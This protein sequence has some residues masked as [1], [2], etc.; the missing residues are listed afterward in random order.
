VSADISLSLPRAVSRQPWMSIQDLL[1]IARAN[2]DNLL[3]TLPSKTLITSTAMLTQQ[4]RLTNCFVDASGSGRA[5]PTTKVLV[6]DSYTPFPMAHANTRM[7]SRAQTL[8]P[9]SSVFFHLPSVLLRAINGTTSSMQGLFHWDVVWVLARANARLSVDVVS[10]QA[11]LSTYANVPVTSLLPLYGPPLTFPMQ[12]LRN[13]SES[14]IFSGSQ[15]LFLVHNPIRR[16]LLLPAN[17]SLSLDLSLSPPPPSSSSS[18]SS[19]PTVPRAQPQRVSVTS[20]VVTTADSLPIDVSRG[21]SGL[22]ITRVNAPTHFV[23]TALPCTDANV[24][25]TRVDSTLALSTS[26]S[27]LAGRAALTLT[28]A[29]QRVD[30]TVADAL[31]WTLTSS[32]VTVHSGQTVVT[33]AHAPRHL[34]VSGARFPPST[35]ATKSSDPEAPVPTPVSEF[36]VM[37][38][39]PGKRLTVHGGSTDNLFTL[40]ALLSLKGSVVLEGTA[41]TFDSLTARAEPLS[42]FYVALSPRSLFISNAPLS[43]LSSLVNRITLTSMDRASLTLAADQNTNGTV[44]IWANAALSRVSLTSIAP[45]GST[46]THRLMGCPSAAA[47]V[48]TTYG[49]QG[50]QIFLIGTGVITGFACRVFLN[51]HLPLSPSNQSIPSTRELHVNASSQSDPLVFSLTPRQL[52]VTNQ[53]TKETLQVYFQSVSAV[54]ITCGIAPCS[55]LLAST[56]PRSLSVLVRFGDAANFSQNVITTPPLATSV[57]LIGP[58]TLVLPIDAAVWPPQN[59]WTPI[60][61]FA[62]AQQQTAIR[63]DSSSLTAQMQWTASSVCLAAR[64]L[65]SP[66]TY[67]S[68]SPSVNAVL[69]QQLPADILVAL[70]SARLLAGLECVVQQGDNADKRT[71]FLLGDGDDVV[72]LRDVRGPVHVHAGNGRNTVLVSGPD[73]PITVQSGDGP[74]TI[75]IARPG[76]V[77]RRSART[78]SADTPEGSPLIPLFVDSGFGADT[79]LLDTRAWAGLVDL[80]SDRNSDR[81]FVFSNDD[82]LNFTSNSRGSFPSE[83]SATGTAL[84][85]GPGTLSLRNYLTEDVVSVREGFLGVSNSSDPDAMLAAALAPRVSSSPLSPSPNSP[86]RV[87]TVSQRTPQRTVMYELGTNVTTIIDACT[88]GNVILLS[89]PTNQAVDSWI[90]HVIGTQ[91][92]LWSSCNITIVAQRSTNAT[93]IFSIAPSEKFSSPVRTARIS[94]QVTAITAGLMSIRVA[95]ISSLVLA[96]EAIVVANSVADSLR[97][98]VLSASSVLPAPTRANYTTTATPT[99][100]ATSLPTQETSTSSRATTST[101]LDLFTRGN[102]PLS[103]STTAPPTT[104]T[105]T[106]IT[107]AT[108]SLTTTSAAPVLSA[109]RPSRQPCAALRRHSLGRDALGTDRQPHCDPGGLYRRSTVTRRGRN[110]LHAITWHAGLDRDECER[111]A[112]SRIRSG[113][114]ARPHSL[115]CPAAAG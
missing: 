83:E 32:D 70:S 65:S 27:A 36:R 77:N 100:P 8:L 92:M 4:V 99:A 104:T 95:N 75:F 41:A 50:A 72:A 109:Q 3:R 82:A 73:S 108:I 52:T 55:V 44:D 12:L 60:L 30:V 90:V 33:L 38:V 47:S 46:V 10:L 69:S 21:C 49:G 59:A 61:S 2:G 28:G 5:V 113:L 64:N 25:E 96:V 43:S 110:A 89:T 18:S 93:L 6:N 84:L 20:T 91:S 7:Q 26:L 14:S 17:A 9:L 57:T 11:S 19:S 87:V 22:F 79:I 35:T 103:P 102:N 23:F 101:L 16:Q 74:D 88:N 76:T 63:L 115:C 45:Y 31:N 24:V 1:A 97:Y 54:S 34:V 29:S 53:A 56:L 78:V 98:L 105:T 15:P 42:N 66:M 37:S 106:V 111:L 107:T 40:P 114:Y 67:T 112:A 85:T 68:P 62:S 86:R 58:H 94:Q 80:G 39:A 51:E 81:V 71:E 48:F 13:A